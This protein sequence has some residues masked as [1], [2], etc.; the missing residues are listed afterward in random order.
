[1]K[2]YVKNNDV[3]RALRVLKKKLHAE[4]DSKTVREKQH[5]VPLGEQK[6]LAA[7]A[8][9]KRWLKKRAQLEQRLQRKEQAHLK[10]RKRTNS[11]NR[12]NKPFAKR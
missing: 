2:I 9:R 6:R 8:G 3:S 5:F 11:S 10:S 4:G 1:M 12:N 7:R